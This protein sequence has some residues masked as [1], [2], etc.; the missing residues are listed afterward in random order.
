MVDPFETI[1]MSYTPVSGKS[2]IRTAFT[3]LKDLFSR[4]ANEKTTLGGYPAFFHK[5]IGIAARFHDE[6]Q[7]RRYF[8]AFGEKERNRL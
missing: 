2:E 4:S 1:M 7:R 3:A 6:P 5:E 8:I